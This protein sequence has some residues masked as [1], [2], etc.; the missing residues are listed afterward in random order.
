MVIV[1]DQIAVIVDLSK[2][3][4][5]FTYIFRFEE[6]KVIVFLIES[7]APVNHADKTGITPLHQAARNGQSKV[8]ETLIRAGAH[9]NATDKDLN[10]PLHMIKWMTAKRKDRPQAVNTRSVLKMYCFLYPF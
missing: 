9:V 6:E 4:K 8:V 7:G 10:T 3:T 2:I 1:Q 5:T